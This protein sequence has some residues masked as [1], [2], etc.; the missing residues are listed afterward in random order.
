MFIRSLIETFFTI[1]LFTVK[2][3]V[4]CYILYAFLT[5]VYPTLKKR[6]A[7][8]VSIKFIYYINQKM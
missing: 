4:F 8:F 3:G 2:K 6:K 1:T 5:F 7:F